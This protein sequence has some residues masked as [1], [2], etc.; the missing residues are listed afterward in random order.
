M[1]V[2]ANPQSL[3]VR[4]D[5]QLTGEYV[6]ELEKALAGQSSDTRKVALDLSRVT[7]ID[8]AGMKFLCGVKSRNVA[9]EKIPSYVTR[10]IEQ[11]AAT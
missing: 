9:I 6:P 5:G 2:Q 8:H 11:K 7:F 4:L 3:R 10:R 1:R